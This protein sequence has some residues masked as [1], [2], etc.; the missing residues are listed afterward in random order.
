MHEGKITIH[1]LP[2]W[3]WTVGSGALTILIAILWGLIWFEG[4]SF[5]SLSGVIGWAVEVVSAV[6]LI[7]IF[8]FFFL[9]TFSTLGIFSGAELIRINADEKFVDCATYSILGRRYNRFQFHQFDRFR[10]YKSKG[11]WREQYYLRLRL[12]NGRNMKFGVP[13]GDEKKLV[14]KLIRELNTYIVGKRND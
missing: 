9:A 5:G 4:Y 6:G 10:S 1:H 8:Y 13:L 3:D 12:I 7:G 14:M 11:L 2:W